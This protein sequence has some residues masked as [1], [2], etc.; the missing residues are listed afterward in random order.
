MST[1]AEPFGPVAFIVPPEIEI[2]RGTVPFVL[3]VEAIYALKKFANLAP[4]LES[5]ES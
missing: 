2:F 5:H 4:R 1:D 3:Y